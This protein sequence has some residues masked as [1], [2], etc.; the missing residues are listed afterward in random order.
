MI[1]DIH[2]YGD[3]CGPKPKHIIKI[4]DIRRWNSTGHTHEVIGYN[5]QYDIIVLR[6]LN[7]NEIFNWNWDDYTRMTSSMELPREDSLKND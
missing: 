1:R 5:N 2:N 3:V 7:D 6:R 4:G